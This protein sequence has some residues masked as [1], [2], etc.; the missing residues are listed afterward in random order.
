[1]PPG[2]NLKP[3]PLGL[4]GVVILKALIP[5]TFNYA[6]ENGYLKILIGRVWKIMGLWGAGS[7]AL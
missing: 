4:R 3:L 1:M 5:R 2:N 6:K 7:F